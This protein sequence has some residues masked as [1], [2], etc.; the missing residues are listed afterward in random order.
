MINLNVAIKEYLLPYSGLLFTLRRKKKYIW[1]A[2]A[3]AFD[4]ESVK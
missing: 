1:K 2:I 3:H 4:R